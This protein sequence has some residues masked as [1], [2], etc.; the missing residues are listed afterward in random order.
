M[1]RAVYMPTGLSFILP[2][3]GVVLQAVK[4]G[5]TIRSAGYLLPDALAILKMREDGT[6]YLKKGVQVSDRQTAKSA[7]A[8]D[9]Q[10][11]HG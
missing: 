1:R 4:P 7:R 10:V 2:P 5:E 9:R 6:V 8:G 3:A 11:G